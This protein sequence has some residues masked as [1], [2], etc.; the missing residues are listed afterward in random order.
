M[1][2]F[3]DNSKKGIYFFEQTKTFLRTFL[4]AFSL[5][6]FFEHSFELFF[7]LF[8]EHFSADYLQIHR[9]R[10]VPLDVLF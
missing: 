1:Q 7:E 6:H 9:N 5:E 2:H 4:S 10:N 3:F 8:F